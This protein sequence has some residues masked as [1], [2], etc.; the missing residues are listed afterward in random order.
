MKKL[1]AFLLASVMTFMLTACGSVPLSGT[2]SGS[3]NANNTSQSVGSASENSINQ[4]NSDTTLKTN[5]ILVVY[6]SLSGTT[7][8][9][10]KR[11]QEKTGGDLYKIETVK[12]YSDNMQAVSDEAKQER[13][14]GNL[15]ELSGDLPD[16]SSYDLILIGGPVWSS[17]L[18]SP[19]MSFLKE[20]DLTGKTVAPF[21]TD[22]GNPGDYAADFESLAV[23]A[24]LRNGLGLSSVSSYE[25][26]ALN[27]ELD[28]WL[29]GLGIVDSVKSPA[30]GTNI[31]MTAGETVITATLN[32]SEAAKEFAASLPQTV[33]LTR[34]GEHEYYGKL[35]Q[36]LTETSQLQTGYE[37]GDIAF[38][39]PG[40]MFVVYFDEPE[41]APEGL[42][43]LGKV[44]T[45]I[46]VFNNMENPEEMKIELK[47]KKEEIN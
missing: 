39:T 24:Q 31:T 12:T 43:I 41:E 1:T 34:Y 42:M 35:A 27:Q 40:D 22:A 46:T 37:V 26:T 33:S 16:V 38:W 4:K 20:V 6:Y 7:E 29:A 23:G 45:D 25:E 30:K 3:D 36:P 18:A 5:K 15:P 44:T 8:G 14:S 19:L 17:T 28:S 13:E 2:Q 47:S 9:I 21:W 10:A 32:N 11:L